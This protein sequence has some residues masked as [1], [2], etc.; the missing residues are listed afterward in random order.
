MRTPRGAGMESLIC[1]CA[2][3]DAELARSLNLWVQIG[4]NYY[5]PVVDPTGGFSI[6]TSGAVRIGEPGTIVGAW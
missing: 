1:K 4:K 3:C 6:V 2:G 5:S